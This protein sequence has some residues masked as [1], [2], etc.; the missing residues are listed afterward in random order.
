MEAACPANQPRPPATINIMD[1]HGDKLL[2]IIHEDDSITDN[3][4]ANTCYEAEKGLDAAFDGMCVKD[5]ELEDDSDFDEILQ[6][7]RPE[8][9][10]STSKQ[11]KNLDTP[12][13]QNK[14]KFM[15]HFLYSKFCIF[16]TYIKIYNF[17]Q[18][19]FNEK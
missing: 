16:Y 1:A 13:C 15:Y 18:I 2:A 3:L 17:V 7:R 12:D 6:R 11:S 19:H 9:L 8:D 4:K 10:Y 5:E 14:V